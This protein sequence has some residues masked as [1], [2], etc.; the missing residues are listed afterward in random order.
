LAFLAVAF[1]SLNTEAWRLAV[2]RVAGKIGAMVRPVQFV[3]WDDPVIPEALAGFDGVF[4]IPGSEAIPPPLLARFAQAQ[5]LV[6]LENDLS[7]CGVPSVHLLPPRF[8]HC[9]GDHLH[10]LGHRHIDCLNTQPPDRV[11]QRRAEQWLLWQRMHKVKGRLINEPVQPFAHPAPKAYDVMHRLLEAGEFKA[12]AL[13]CLT[14]EAATG[15]IRALQEHELRVG[16]DVSVCAVEGGM[17]ARLQCPS[18]TVLEPPEPDVYV[19]LCVDWFAR[20]TEPWV[21]PLLVEPP[22]LSLFAGES[23]G[24]PRRRVPAAGHR[25]SRGTLRTQSSK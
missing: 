11:I 5:H 22:T 18:R 19:E 17:T 13:V 1:Y 10:R 15:A 20:R 3:H 9:L 4:L 21:G 14:N 8:I 16:K 23:T 7:D 12:T 6:S 24:P 25:A 2:D